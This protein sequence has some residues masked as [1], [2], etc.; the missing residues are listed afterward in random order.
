MAFT[1]ARM[2]LEADAWTSPGLQRPEYGLSLTI[3]AYNSDQIFTFNLPTFNF[4]HI[5]VILCDRWL[6]VVRNTLLPNDFVSEEQAN[7]LI[8]LF[9][10]LEGALSQ[11]HG[12]P[13]D[14]AL[15]AV[16]LYMQFLLPAR[17][18]QDPTDLFALTSEELRSRDDWALR[19]AARV[20]PPP[21]NTEPTG[22]PSPAPPAIGSNGATL[23]SDGQL[24]CGTDLPRGLVV[25]SDA[26]GDDDMPPL[27][28]PT[29]SE[30]EIG[31]F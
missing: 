23:V 11:S 28:S 19:H 18:F 12:D 22:A 9:L 1:E 16:V 29:S 31:D 21:I 3:F 27:I 15:A 20:A 17:L 8:D 24:V 25:A 4:G 6:H 30:S 10:L 26:D 7:L 5:V 13:A 2:V 14:E